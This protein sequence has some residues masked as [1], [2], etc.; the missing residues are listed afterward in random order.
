MARK[1]E[2]T[3]KYKL[4]RKEYGYAKWFSLKYPEWLDEYNSLKD[5]VKAIAYD[6]EGHGSGRVNDSTG[7]LAARR[8]EIRR[9]MLLVE[10]AAFDAGGDIGEFIL[11]SVINEDVT[12]E[13]MKAQGLPC[14]RTMYYERRRKYY[15]LLSKEI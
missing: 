4:S 12:F 3:G 15:Y 1:M 5:S 11:K 14:E 6:Q 13:D 9:K 7:D 2:Y 10:H 8:A